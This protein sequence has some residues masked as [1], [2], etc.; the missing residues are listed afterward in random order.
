MAG[1]G[2]FHS[3]LSARHV[4]SNS[5]SADGRTVKLQRWVIGGEDSYSNLPCHPWK[6]CPVI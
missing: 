2:S 5:H 3:I 1:Q 6:F 4:D